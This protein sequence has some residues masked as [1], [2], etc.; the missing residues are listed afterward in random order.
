M[1][2]TR[3]SFRVFFYR[4]DLFHNWFFPVKQ[5]SF[6]LAFIKLV[7]NFVS[8]L[9]IKFHRFWVVCFQPFLLS[10]SLFSARFCI[11]WGF[12]RML[13]W[14]SR[15]CLYRD[16]YVLSAAWFSENWISNSLSP[17]R[18]LFWRLCVCARVHVCSHACAREGEIEQVS[19]F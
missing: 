14:H 17:G 5:A 6:N 2:G 11:P 7:T 3:V 9:V 15:K 18:K 8:A 10:A 12:L 16:I 19:A 13:L 4:S 1:A